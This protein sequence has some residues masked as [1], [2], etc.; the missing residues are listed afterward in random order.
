MTEPE[1]TPKKAG[2]KK[3]II[4]VPDILLILG[5]VL[6]F[7]GLGFAISWPAAMAVSGAILIGLSIWLVEPRNS[8]EAKPDAE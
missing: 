4:E 2:G 3:P 8:K 1:K 6:L 5:L 7:T